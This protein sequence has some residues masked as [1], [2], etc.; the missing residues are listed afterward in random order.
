MR[1]GGIQEGKRGVSSSYCREATYSPG[2]VE[3]KIV[4]NSK[5]KYFT[6][7]LQEK[8]LFNILKIW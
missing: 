6:K 4:K 5:N 1:N 7:A 2:N 8:K 3:Q